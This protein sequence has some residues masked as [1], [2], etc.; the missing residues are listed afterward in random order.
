M[1]TRIFGLANVALD[2]LHAFYLDKVPT[3]SF[4]PHF[5]TLMYIFGCYICMLPQQKCY[6]QNPW[7]WKH[8]VWHII[9]H[10]ISY[11]FQIMAKID[12]FDNGCPLIC[13]IL[14]YI[15][16]SLQ[17]KLYQQNPWP[18]KHRFRHINLHL[19][20]DRS[21]IM[22]KNAF[23]GNGCPNLHNTV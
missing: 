21:W 2:K 1:V 12:F 6:Y 11:S 23:F 3:L 9:W 15:C 13:I 4:F 16:M 14:C 19:I 17:Q 8:R 22:A 18:W 20:L 5:Q 10:H 7:P